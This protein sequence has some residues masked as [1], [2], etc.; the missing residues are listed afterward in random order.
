MAHGAGGFRSAWAYRRW[1]RYLISLTVSSIG[2]FMY[3]VGLAVYLVEETGSATWLAA[4]AIVRML[5]YT[6]LGPV[7]GV[8]ADRY[9][10]RRLMVA[11]DAGR[12]ALMMLAGLAIVGDASPWIVVAL[13]SA[14]AALTTPY[15]PAAV[16][17]T[18]MLVGE[19]D[20]AG[21]N[22]AEASVS[23]LAWFL[24][25][26]LGAAVV[27]LSDPAAAFFVN[28]ITFA[29][30]GVLI[31]GVGGIGRG[32]RAEPGHDPG[33][34]AQLVEGG[35]A[36]RQVPGLAALTVMLVAVLFA[37]GIETVVQVLVVTERL[38]RD[39]GSVGVL[40]ACVG[41]GGLLA[42]PFSAKLAG[43]RDAGRMLAVS[44]LLMGA[45]L[46]L[47][48]VVS[49]FYLACAL[50]V[51]EGVGNIVLDV[52]V[53]TLLQRACPE[54]LLGR[55][56]SLQDSA[57]SLAQLVGSIAAPTLIAVGNLELA[58]VVGGVSL[59]VTSVL[60][61]RPL[62]NISK[63]TEAERA[64]L[65]PVVAELGNLGIFGDASRA[66]LERLARASSA[67]EVAAGDTV[68]AEG[69]EPTD[70][71]VIRSGRF[72]VTTATD[73]ELSRLGPG[74]WFGEIGLLRRVPRTATVSAAADG[75]LLAI[76]GERFLAALDD[77]E[78]LPD[79]LGITM[80]TRLVRTHPELDEVSIADVR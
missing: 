32:S 26:A 54:R 55:V 25:P 62:Q 18:P 31:A 49:N 44:G 39:A 4:A 79:P 27:A 63:R 30:S 11:L 74:D 8:I 80:R 37:F 7:G 29:I 60:L 59:V 9:D 61:A 38:G 36:I 6:L 64:A 17:A 33:A 42:V 20:L 22:A 48:S 47:L 12:V 77:L 68:F 1:R 45:P 65:A 76:D 67:I 19:D 71:Y 78:R 3:A 50:M 51:V 41:V 16:A 2:D 43:R 53:V 15:R 46:A 5:T 13:A 73:G 75:Q 72:V 56:F 24:G 35:R 66:S 58:L 28:G 21:A 14:T 70:L 40:L 10:R 57:S 23:Q 69:A 34:L 52:L